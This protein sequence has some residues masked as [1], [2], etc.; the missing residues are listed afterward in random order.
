MT[1]RPG[2]PAVAGA[3]AGARPTLY[4]YLNP[5]T[6]GPH[7]TGWPF[8]ADL[9]SANVFQLLEAVEGVERVEE[10]LFFEYDLRNHERVGFGKELVKLEP[11]L[12]VPV[13]RPPGGGAMTTRRDDWLVHQLPVG[14]VEDE[15]L[16]R[17]L[18]IFQ[19][20]ADTV[21]DQVDNL[22]H[23][24]DADRRPAADGPR[25]RRLDRPRLGRPVTARRRCSGA[26][27]ASTS[28]CCAGAARS[29]ACASCSS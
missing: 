19:D 5:L 21:I 8:D 10:V 17:F 27:C 6:G 18:S 29:A 7:G 20:V 12:A 25:A 4:R 1:A 2:R 3:R 16:V 14:M 15:F 24:F 26:S 22:P 11:R 13:R 23:M 28:R 9:N